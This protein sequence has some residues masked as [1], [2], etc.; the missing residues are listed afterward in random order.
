MPEGDTIFRA[1]RTLHRALAGRTVVRFESA[2]PALTRIHHDHPV[3]GRTITDVRSRGKHLLMTFSGD[4]I[5]HTHMRM[6]GSWHIYRPGEAWQ[7]P[8]RDMRIV[9]ATEAFVAV[10][11]NV[12][13]A[14][15]LTSRDVERHEAL[16]VLGSDP[17]SQQF[18]RQDVLKR[19]REHGSEAIGDVLLNQRVVAGIG[20]VLK[21]E[22]LF[23]GRVCPFALVNHL[24][25][26]T[27]GRL[28][29][30]A[31]KLLA[32]NTREGNYGNA[33]RHRRT[34][35]RMNP[36]E[37]LWVYG[38]GGKPCR[39]CGTLIQSRKGGIDARLT[40]WC[41]GCQG[42]LKIED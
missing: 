5:L 39:K 37:A 27:L 31:Q 32:L 29:D 25:D 41:G 4:L 10:G 30:V 6:N 2:F 9:V 7:R 33:Q 22:A 11:F 36:A 15:F 12:P 8:F 24:D 23:V 18:D 35:G 42:E 26:A 14:E 17:L 3:T 40:Y 34:N 20:N 1:A 13:V 19:M 38:R 28:V 21:C 16:S